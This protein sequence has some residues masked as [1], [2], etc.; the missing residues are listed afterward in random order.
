[1]DGQ[2]LIKKLLVLK[3]LAVLKIIIIREIFNKLRREK[4]RPKNATPSDPQWETFGLHVEI[5]QLYILATYSCS[6]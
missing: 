2:I 6:F 5:A 4:V 1:M 3:H